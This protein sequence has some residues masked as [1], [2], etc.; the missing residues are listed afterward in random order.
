VALPLGAWATAAVLDACEAA[1]RTEV[2]GG[3]DAAVGIGLLG[4]I[5]SAITGLADWQRVG[6]G[7]N[8][9]LGTVHGLTN[10]LA[11]ALYATSLLARR[12]GARG[13]GRALGWAGLAVVSA[14]GWLGGVLVFDRKLGVDHAEREGLPTT[15]TDVLAASELDEGTMRRV[16]VGGTRVLLVRQHGKLHAIGEVCSHLGGPLAEGDLE[17]GCVRCP[18]HGSRFALATGEV[19]RGPATMPQPRLECRERGGQIEVRQVPN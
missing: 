14:G 7:T 3:A 17:D 1:G 6:K 15:W 13:A 4:A 9:R 16:V 19:V 5:G 12:S 10:I 18:W 8:R 2:A 11:T